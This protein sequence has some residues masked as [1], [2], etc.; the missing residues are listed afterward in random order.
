MRSYQQRY[1]IFKLWNKVAFW[2]SHCEEK[3][4]SLEH[5]LRLVRFW[6]IVSKLAGRRAD[7]K[8]PI[9]VAYT[10]YVGYKCDFGN[11]A[12][13]CSGCVSTYA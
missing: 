9:S 6:N 13:W 1:A 2:A 7:I 4:Y 5:G 12:H 10:A 11:N 8:D 3:F